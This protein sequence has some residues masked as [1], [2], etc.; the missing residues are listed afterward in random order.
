MAIE[1]ISSATGT[2]SAT[3]PSHQADDVIIAFAFRDGSTTRPT[4][5]ADWTPIRDD[6][7]TTCSARLA[8]RIAVDGTTTSGT[9]TNA[10]SVIFVIYRGAF[11]TPI[12][13]ASFSS[14]SSTTVTY[15]ALTTGQN[16]WAIG[17]AG[18]RSANVNLIA[19]D[20]MTNRAYVED[21]TDEA[22]AHDTNSNI[23]AWTSKDTSVGG[24]ASGWIT[25]TLEI[26]NLI[27]ATA[28][29]SGA[30]SQIFTFLYP[31]SPEWYAWFFDDRILTG[32]GSANYL[33]T[34][35]ESNTE[36]EEVTAE[37]QSQ[38]DANISITGLELESSF[39]SITANSSSIKTI[40]GLEATSEIGIIEEI[41]QANL[42]LDG[43]ELS[44][45]TGTVTASAD[46]SVS[47]SI[48]GISLASQT[49]NVSASG[50]GEMQMVP[51]RISYQLP[52]LNAR[53]RIDGLILQAQ[54]SDL[55]ASGTI[56]INNTAK[57]MSIEAALNLK[58]IQANGVWDVEENDL[59]L[60]LAA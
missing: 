35:Q 23:N 20:G 38:I 18:H 34:G 39:E 46:G 57:I 15:N 32:T 41:G 47:V 40:E 56:I 19:P 51:G 36:I 60:L 27:N 8:Y 4:L 52:K 14:G 17:F 30:E 54:A 59:I 5:P 16:S 1:F 58:K 48:T 28:N 2:T 37:G 9:W 22:A 13:N 11:S 26:K 43:Q 10:T 31:A 24:T 25:Y 21:A 12:G 50:T 33:I 42:L 6:P 44:S 29:V 45:A 3:L 53:T 49:G 7:G 55:L